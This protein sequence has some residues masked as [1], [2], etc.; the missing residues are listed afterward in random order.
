MD[1]DFIWHAVSRLLHLKKANILCHV[2][3]KRDKDLI[4][5][6]NQLKPDGQSNLKIEPSFKSIPVASPVRNRLPALNTTSRTST[7]LYLKVC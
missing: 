3:A 2:G 6:T 5:K 7:D 1:K 4:Y